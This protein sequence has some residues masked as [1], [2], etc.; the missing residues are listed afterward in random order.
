LS[1]L[2]VT[3]FEPRNRMQPPSWRLGCFRRSANQSAYKECGSLICTAFTEFIGGYYLKNGTYFDWWS[4]N[5]TLNYNKKR[6]CLEDLDIQAGPYVETPNSQPKYVKI[7]GTYVARVMI[8][9]IGALRTA[10]HVSYQQ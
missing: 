7:D 8:S 6:A 10:Y 3:D 1:R 4:K 9:E 5:T 2:R